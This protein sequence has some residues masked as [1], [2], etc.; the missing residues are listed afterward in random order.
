MSPK[1]K[2]VFYSHTLK[3]NLSL[4]SNFIRLQ[5]DT[6]TKWN[7]DHD[8]LSP[9]SIAIL[10]FASEE[11]L[12]DSANWISI[13]HNHLRGHYS[14]LS[15]QTQFTTSQPA[16]CQIQLCW[17]SM[18]HKTRAMLTPPPSVWLWMHPI[19][20][21]RPASPGPPPPPT[22]KCTHNTQIH[23]HTMALE[24]NYK[25][26]WTTDHVIKQ[27]WHEVSECGHPVRYASALYV[28]C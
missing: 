23:A 11:N 18:G 7:P 26:Y 28:I 24:G 3:W 4:F 9:T 27:V 10:I 25:I 13:T 21:H 19:T 16:I 8:C 14:S 15:A 12:Y 6:G 2:V 17:S 20:I 1:Q 22:H 5:V